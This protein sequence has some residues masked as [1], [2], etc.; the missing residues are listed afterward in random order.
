MLAFV[1]L[2][3]SKLIKTTKNYKYS[4]GYLDIRCLD[5]LFWYYLKLEDM[6]KLKVKNVNK[7]Q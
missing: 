2:V 1:K 6:L 7:K 3:I 5:H 4:I